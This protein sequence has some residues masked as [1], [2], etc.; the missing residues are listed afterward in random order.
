LL[1]TWGVDA[2]EEKALDD[3]PAFL[4]KP[5]GNR[6]YVQPASGHDVIMGVAK[7]ELSVLNSRII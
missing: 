7:E 5:H 3:D 6:F 4:G 2:I 1:F